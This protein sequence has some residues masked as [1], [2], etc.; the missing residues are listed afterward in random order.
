MLGR[1]TQEGLRGKLHMFSAERD[2]GGLGESKWEKWDIQKG[3]R[4][5]Q[6]TGTLPLHHRCP[7]TEAKPKLFIVIR[8]LQ[9]H[10]ASWCSVPTS[11]WGQ[12][13]PGQGTRCLCPHPTESHL[14]PSS[15]SAEPQARLQHGK[16]GCA[17]DCQDGRR[18]GDRIL[19]LLFSP[20]KIIPVAYKKKGQTQ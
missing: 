1:Q 9:G 5:V 2:F 13:C 17:G 20:A 18:G 11:L 8:A 14:N 4:R 7:T 12:P 6:S 19:T 10:R 16:G 15:R 3:G